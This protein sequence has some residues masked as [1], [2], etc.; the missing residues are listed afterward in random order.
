MHM[1]IYYM[2]VP[3]FSAKYIFHAVR[4]GTKVTSY[5]IFLNTL[6]PSPVFTLYKVGRALAWINATSVQTRILGAQAASVGYVQN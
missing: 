4:H 1:Q 2:P 5:I 3:F 6:Q